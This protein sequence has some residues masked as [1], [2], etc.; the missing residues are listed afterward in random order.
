[1]KRHRFT[2]WLPYPPGHLFSIIS[3]VAE[4]H[5]FVPLCV[6]ADVWDVKED[7]PLKTFRA[8]LEI[9]YPR[10]GLQE[11]YVSDVTADAERMLVIARSSEGAV[12]QLE[13]RWLFTPRRDGT[14]VRFALQFEMASRFLQLAMDAAFDYAANK[15]FDAF[16]RRAEELVRQ[17][18]LKT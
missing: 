11:Y 15:I 14:D 7:G 3:D 17:G 10:L 9:A 6:G 4:Y 12:R 16:Q 13:N 18:A 5:R 2:R 8:K 1:M